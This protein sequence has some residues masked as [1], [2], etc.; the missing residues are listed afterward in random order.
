MTLPSG[1]ISIDDLYTESD[2][3]S[4][5][6]YSL[7]EIARDSYFQG[8]N[9][10]G[11]NDFNGFGRDGGNSGADRIFDFSAGTSP[12]S[13]GQFQSKNYFYDGANFVVEVGFNNQLSPPPPPPPTPPPTPPTTSFYKI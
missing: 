11:A 5:T 6:V 10:S 2:S 7:A 13:M 9:G 3:G 12:Q 4:A 8:V 1:Q